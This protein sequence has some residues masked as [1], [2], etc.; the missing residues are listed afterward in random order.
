VY[1]RMPAAEAAR[2]F[3]ARVR[4][5]CAPLLASG[6]DA[7]V[8]VFLDGENAWEYYEE[9]GR[10]FLRELYRLIGEDRRMSAVTVSEAIERVASREIGHVF[11]GSWINANFDIW[12]G[13]E[14]D[15][16]A[17]EHLH[18]ARETYERCRSLP[19]P[20]DK[21]RLAYEEL[22][23]AEGSDWYWWYG[24]EHDSANRPEFDQLFRGHLA[25]VYTLLGLT[26]PDELS[27][28]ILHVRVQEF[29][30]TPTGPV[31]PA[32]D[33]VVTSYF[34]W[35]G[36]GVYRVDQRTGAMHGKRF[37]VRELRYGSDGYNMYLRIDFVEA[38]EVT[39]D[40]TEL[41]IAV[42]Q[43]GSP[44]A[45]VMRSVRLT[46]HTDGVESAYEKVCEVKVSLGSMGVHHGRDV[47][48]QLSVWQSGL[49]VEALPPQGWIELSTS[50]PT[51]MVF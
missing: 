15:N 4:E 39:A 36:A 19:V 50:E 5:A 13:D 9:S 25:N 41:R 10:P 48:F 28:P 16:R 7:L 1:H 22:L 2:D 32:I 43:D 17:W 40:G 12:I 47:R 33:G 38:A 3:V 14:E 23:I 45:P 31:Q 46:G 29:H 42:Q 51:D 30:Q 21:R 20:D 26:P 49:P 6:E 24:P 37:F 35:L 18:K 44:E 11:P 8:P 34:E 27:R